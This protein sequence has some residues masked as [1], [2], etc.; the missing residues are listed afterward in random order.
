MC[1]DGVGLCVVRLIPLLRSSR[2]KCLAG[3]EGEPE[4]V[5]E[6]VED[7][8]G[9]EGAGF[10]PGAAVEE[11]NTL[12]P[13]LPQGKRNCYERQKPRKGSLV[14]DALWRS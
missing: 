13:S 4:G 10:H 1:N 3:E 11:A 14:S 6:G 12:R 7:G 8:G 2:G 9:G 5:D